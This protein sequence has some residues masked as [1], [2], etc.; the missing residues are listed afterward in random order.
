MPLRSNRRGRQENRAESRFNEVAEGKNRPS[1]ASVEKQFSD[2]LTN[3]GTET[4]SP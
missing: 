4:E 1:E 3:I 2:F